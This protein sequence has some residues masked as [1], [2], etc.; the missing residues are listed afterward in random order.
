MSNILH[1]TEQAR[2]GKL[3]NSLKTSVNAAATGQPS[4]VDTCLTSDFL[5]YSCTSDE[6]TVEIYIRK[7]FGLVTRQ[8]GNALRQY[9]SEVQY[10]TTIV[11][12]VKISPLGHF[13]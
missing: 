3:V 4:W 8:Y 6:I 2:H 7:Y 1:D 9:T 5:V 11:K 12:P 13:R 10:I